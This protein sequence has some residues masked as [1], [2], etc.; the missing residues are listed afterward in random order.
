MKK[1]NLLF[2]FMM[3][4]TMSLFTGC[5]D[6]D[7]DGV[8]IV[9][10]V[11]ATF[12]GETLQL[13]Y[14]ETEL[15][16]KEVTFD[17]KDGKTATIV[18]KGKFDM[19]AI[20]GIIGGGSKANQPV[21]ELASGVIPGEVKT[22]IE[23][24]VLTQE[25]EKYTFEGTDEQNGRTVKYTG[26]VQKD[27]MVLAL[28]VTMPE[29]PLLGAT[30]KMDG[31]TFIWKSSVDL[32][33]IFDEPYEMENAAKLLNMFLIS[34]KLKAL[35]K[36]VTFQA[37]GNI[38]ATYVKDGKDVVSPINL[39][40]YY[41]KDGKLYVT[42]NIDMIIQAATKADNNEELMKLITDLMQTPLMSALS[43]GF[44]LNCVIDDKGVAN[45]YI[46]EAFLKPI[47]TVVLNNAFVMDKITSILP[48][49]NPAIGNL[50]SCYRYLVLLR[51]VLYIPIILIQNMGVI[52]LLMIFP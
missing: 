4:C 29:N 9:D 45:I 14:S 20:G 27:K 50:S 34:P 17:T 38:V 12:S 18:M 49:D 33:Q 7:E 10:G 30:W 13:T 24:V 52:F 2:L 39:A 42:L 6:D 21:V 37:D 46:D 44:P 36:D 40:N 47:L 8:K 43:E 11:N 25:G 28:E 41:F 35:L 48:N 51:N 1:K 22:L 16:G 3:L 15:L 32:E 23:N 19:G 5:S 31:S 26:E